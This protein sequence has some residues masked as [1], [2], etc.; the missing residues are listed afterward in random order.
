MDGPGIRKV[1]AAYE[2]AKKKNLAIVAG[3]Q[4]RHQAGYLETMKRIH[5]GA[6]G[7]I[8][9][10]RCYWNQGDPVVHRAQAG[11]GAT[12]SS[13]SATGINFTWLCGDHIVEQHVHNLDVINWAFKAASRCRPSAWAAAA[14]HGPELSATSSTTS[15]STTS[16][17]TASTC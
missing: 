9:G 16:I 11:H 2:E 1:L 14:A 12:W 15:P 5:D 6:I 3:T 13:R 8:V 7:D 4:R 10:G 17:P